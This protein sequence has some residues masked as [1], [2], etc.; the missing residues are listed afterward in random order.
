MFVLNSDKSIL[1][2]KKKKELSML[3]LPEELIK[4]LLNEGSLFFS[5]QELKKIN[6]LIKFIL[7]TKASN[8]YHPSMRGYISHPIRVTS[9]YLRF[10]KKPSLD[11]VFISLLHNFFEISSVK[12]KALKEFG[13]SKRICKAIGTL[14]VNRNLEKK[15]SYLKKYY[16]NI[17]NFSK[18]LALIKCLDKLDNLLAVKII[19][20]N[21]E[22][23]QYVEVAEE[24]VYPIAKKISDN[25][26]IFFKKIIYFSY[27]EKYDDSFKK[28]VENFNKKLLN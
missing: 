14:T 10:S 25:L 3:K 16:H 13:I 26:S 5:K 2:E 7:S 21:S 28:K 24:F 1:E 17:E 18:S 20:S 15:K 6:D 22:R 9:F 23:R 11:Y 19:S 8:P 27:N 4:S 12:E